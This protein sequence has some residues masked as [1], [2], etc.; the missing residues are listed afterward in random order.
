MNVTAAKAARKTDKSTSD[1]PGY[2]RASGPVGKCSAFAGKD[3]A[4]AD[5]CVSTGVFPLS[6]DFEAERNGNKRVEFPS[7]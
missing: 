3:A 7:R 5:L 6:M 4:L 2:C 1:I